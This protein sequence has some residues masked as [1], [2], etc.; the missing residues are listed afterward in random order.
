MRG[1][2]TTLSPAIEARPSRPLVRFRV[3]NDVS[4]DAPFGLEVQSNARG[5]GRFFAVQTSSAPPREVND[6]KT[7]GSAGNFLRSSISRSKRERL[8]E[9][10]KPRILRPDREF[11]PHPLRQCA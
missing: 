11:E 1:A 10:S 6:R 7:A 8:I 9:F 3:A 4:M 5:S 2:P